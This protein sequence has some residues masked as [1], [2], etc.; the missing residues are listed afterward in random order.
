MRGLERLV[1]LVDER[2]Y[3]GGLV[4]IGAGFATVVYYYYYYYYRLSISSGRGKRRWRG[5]RKSALLMMMTPSI[6]L[7]RVSKRT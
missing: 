3:G 4:R 6:K 1:R 7:G 5:R 2:R